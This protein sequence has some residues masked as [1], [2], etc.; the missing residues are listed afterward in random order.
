MVILSTISIVVL[1]TENQMVEWIYSRADSWQLCGSKSMYESCRCIRS[2]GTVG[3]LCIAHVFVLFVGLEYAQLQVFLPPFRA[4]F[5]RLRAWGLGGGGGVI[6]RPFLI[7]L[8]MQ[9]E[10]LPF[11]SAWS[12]LENMIIKALLFIMGAMIYYRICIFRI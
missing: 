5:C 6:L 12:K 3:V 4:L 7:Y 2:Q 8:P 10:W 9:R 11:N 1:I